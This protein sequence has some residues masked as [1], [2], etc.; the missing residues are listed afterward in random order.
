MFVG[1]PL[2]FD[3]LLIDNSGV[4][5]DWP[6]TYLKNRVFRCLPSERIGKNTLKISPLWWVIGY[7][8]GYLLCISSKYI[9]STLLLPAKG[10]IHVEYR[11]YCTLLYFDK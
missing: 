9:S 7:Y 2:S 1:C 11:H 3:T 5:I 10:V 4:D 6:L 8:M